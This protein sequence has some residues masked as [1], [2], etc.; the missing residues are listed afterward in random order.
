ME[1]DLHFA[2]SRFLNYITVEKGLSPNTIESYK[3]DLTRYISYIEERD[4]HSTEDVTISLIREYLSGL[5]KLSMSTSSI[6]RHISSIRHFH[7][8]M[9]QEGLTDSNPAT[10]IETPKGWQRLPKTLSFTEV[11][12]LLKQPGEDIRMGLRDGAMIELL[13]ATGLRV[14]ELVNLKYVNL[15]L[16]VGFITTVGKGGKERVVPMGEYAL[17]KVNIYIERA[18]PVLLKGRS[19]PFVFVSTWGRGLTR[20]S[21]WNIIKKYARQAGI[22][23]DISPHTLRHSFATHLLERGADLRS[24]QM[25]LGHSDISTTQIYTHI[26]RERLKRIHAECHPRP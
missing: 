13:Y 18:R 5:I 15:N 2:L 22:Q 19:S 26:N 10:Y 17:E 25:M 12:A 11:E 14:S 16:E 21:F 3:N 4:A 24:V 1:K 7:K 9:V 20:Q 6:K 23:K 8:F